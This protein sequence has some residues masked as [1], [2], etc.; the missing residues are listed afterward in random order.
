[1]HYTLAILLAVVSFINAVFLV[2]KEG[3]KKV[4]HHRDY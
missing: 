3:F 4:S 1:M 2:A